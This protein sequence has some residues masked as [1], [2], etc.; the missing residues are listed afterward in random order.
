[1]QVSHPSGIIKK[2]LFKAQKIQSE[3]HHSA[4]WKIPKCWIFISAGEGKCM[5]TY[6]MWTCMNNVARQV[7]PEAT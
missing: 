1:M 5:K 2:K 7:S 4:K 3:I 6:K